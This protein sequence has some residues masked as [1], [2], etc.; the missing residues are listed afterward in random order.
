VSCIVIGHT[1]FG[2][3]LL[4]IGFRF[5]FTNDD[6]RDSLW[7]V[8]GFKY[9]MSTFL[10]F[11]NYFLNLHAFH[12]L[13]PFPPRINPSTLDRKSSKRPNP[14]E[15]HPEVGIDKVPNVGGQKESPLPSALGVPPFP[16]HRHSMEIVAEPVLQPIAL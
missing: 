15:D 10:L 14:P 1:L 11:P 8:V 4:A 9:P 3:A 13:S 16:Q 2:P 12:P 7:T 5:A 6:K